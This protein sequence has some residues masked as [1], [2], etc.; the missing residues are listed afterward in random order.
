MISIIASGKESLK[1]LNGFLQIIS[2]KDIEVNVIVDTF[3]VFEFYDI[4]IYPQLTNVLLLLMKQLNET[5]WTGKQNDSLEIST[6]LQKIDEGF[7]AP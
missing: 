4:K 5:Q 3:D 2:P 6:F 1:F 7:P